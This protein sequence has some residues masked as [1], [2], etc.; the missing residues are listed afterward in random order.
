MYQMKKDYV[1]P[2]NTADLAQ[3][4]FKGLNLIK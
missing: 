4:A 1:A 2:V 3:W